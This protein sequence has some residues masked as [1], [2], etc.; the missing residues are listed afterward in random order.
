[1]V[2]LC[3]VVVT[4]VGVDALAVLGGAAPPGQL[5]AATLDARGLQ[6]EA[7]RDAFL[8]AQGRSLDRQTRGSYRVKHE[9]LGIGVRSA[10]P[11]CLHVLDPRGLR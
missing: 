11:C 9:I 2:V 10:V 4:S 5:L 1:M 6:A 3:H 8:E 7:G